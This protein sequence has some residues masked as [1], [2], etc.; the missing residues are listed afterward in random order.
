MPPIHKIIL[1]AIAI[2]SG[3]IANRASAADKP[4]EDS[5]DAQGV[6]IHYIVQ[7]TGEPVV[8]IHGLAS[9]VWINWQM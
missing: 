6:K 8:L 9:S 2:L 4:K 1:I 3:A 5:F 7:G